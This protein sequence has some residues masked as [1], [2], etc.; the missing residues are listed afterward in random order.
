MSPRPPHEHDDE[1][2]AALSELPVPDHGP[3]FWADLDHRLQGETTVQ[4]TESVND[5]GPEQ[6]EQ[7]EPRA[8]SLDEQRARREAR[9]SGR[10]MPRSLGAAAAAVALVVAAAGT[11]TVLNR[12]DDPS[13]EVRTA[14]RPSGT[15]RPAPPTPDAPAELYATYSGSDGL[16][17]TD[18]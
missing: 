8:V 1:L 11:I 16:Q 2:G 10:R 12:D 5:A 13:R 15:A 3:T 17:G 6:T 7:S 4:K 14:A 18:E 9:R